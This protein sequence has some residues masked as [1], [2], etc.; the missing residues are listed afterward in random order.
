MFRNI[1]LI[2]LVVFTN[3]L[4]FPQNFH[5]LEKFDGNSFE[6]LFLR[7]KKYFNKNYFSADEEKIKF[8]LFKDKVVEIFK[9]NEDKS[10][11]YKKGITKF[12]DLNFNERKNFIMEEKNAK[13]VI[14]F[15]LFCL[16]LF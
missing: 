8:N 10:N 2:S 12:S 9:F 5:E 6:N 11:L 3:S 15:F 13:E 1:F 16:F 4:E 7:Y 14:F